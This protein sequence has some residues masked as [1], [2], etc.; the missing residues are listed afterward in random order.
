MII[1]APKGTIDITPKDVYKWHYIEKKLRNIAD[2]YNFGEIRTPNFEHTELFQRGVGD[3]TDVVSKEMY[4]F[5][6]K[7]DR[8]ITLRPEGTAGAARSFIETGMYAESQPTKLYYIIPCY[9]YEK[10]QAGR[11]RE[12]RQFGV[13]MYG[14]KGPSCDAEIIS[15]AK[16]IFEELGIK[17]LALNINNI[18]C[19]ECRKE[20]NEKLIS[21]LSDKKDNLCD[22]CKSRLEKNPMRIFDCKSK[23]CQDIV[24]DAPTMFD[25]VC[26]D[27]KDH[28]DKVLM[29]LDN[30]NIEYNIDKGIVRGLDY[31]TKTVF[32]FVS[33][34]I[35]A[36]GTVCG[37]G[38]YDNLI[39]EIGGKSIPGIGFAIG[40]E[41]L[42]LVM[43]SLNI[44]FESEK[45]VSLFVVSLDEKA[46][47][48][49]SKIV[50]D[51][52]KKNV[53]CEKDFM[54]RTLKAQLKYA[55]KINAENTVVIGEEEIL[56]NKFN[57]KNMDT[58]ETISL[59]YDELLN[60]FGGK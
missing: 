13:E 30:M 53:K 10:P 42:L 23:V 36:Q 22:T 32:E 46:D 51:L 56:N 54:S 3:T 39:E 9:R 16:R 34:D 27:C 49:A 58:G 31:Y 14:A 20:Y 15:V 4:T 5:L 43:E 25:S 21:F 7:G 37:G 29:Y 45:R 47:V 6:D 12:F 35:G 2:I 57:V 11:L 59:T 55:N 33:T 50:N 48:Y 44:P 28:F 52:R 40:L 1:N 60:K 19:P 26:D 18:G 41:R 38:R 8:S 17:K 24:Q